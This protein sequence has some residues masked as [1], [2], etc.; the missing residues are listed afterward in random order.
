MSVRDIQAKDEQHH[1]FECV[2]VC[3]A[4]GVVHMGVG[5]CACGSVCA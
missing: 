5:V 2:C 1:V 4:E 3:V